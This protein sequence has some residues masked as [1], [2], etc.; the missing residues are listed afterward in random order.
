MKISM[1]PEFDEYA[2][3]YPELLH[4]P[5]RSQFAADPIFFHERKWMVIRDFF[6]R[7]NLNIGTSTWLDVGCGQGQLLRVAN[8]SFARAVGC[9]PSAA[10][11]HSSHLAEVYHQPSE[12]EL[13]FPS[14]TFDFVTAVCVYHHVHGALRT[15]LTESIRRVLRPG[16][17]FCMIE[18]NPWNPVTQRIVKRC[19]VD[20]DAELLPASTAHRLMR[21]SGFQI[22]NTT[23]FLFL[24]EVLYRRAAWLEKTLVH[25]PM[26]GQFAVFCRTG[27]A[28]E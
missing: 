1:M 2:P 24:P 5:L 3:T 25:M 16:G 19:P 7:H 6:V 10:M 22:L 26:G 17:V 8:G 27:Y 20:R 21:E 9:D 15:T 4:D 13:P 28:C 18:H 11:I 12:V 14:N 23:N